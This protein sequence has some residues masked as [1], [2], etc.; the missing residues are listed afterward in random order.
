MSQEG[1][2]NHAQPAPTGEMK[3][4]SD[5]TGLFIS[6]DDALTY[7]GALHAVMNHRHDAISEAQ[8]RELMELLRE[9]HD[10][11]IGEVQ[12]MRAF[13]EC[14]ITSAVIDPAQRT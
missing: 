10:D 12:V 9:A 5:R 1:L 11:T 13:G 2:K 3:F 14:R 8:V 6:H 4:A 7:F